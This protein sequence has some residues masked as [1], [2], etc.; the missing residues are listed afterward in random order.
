MIRCFGLT[1]CVS[2]MTLVSSGAESIR[3]TPQPQKFRTF[4][5]LS[6]RQVP[7]VLRRSGGTR[8][9]ATDGAEW[10]GIANGLVRLDPL[11][12]GGDRRQYF[13]G[14]RYLPDDRVRALLA[15]ES[16]GV[17]VRTETGVSH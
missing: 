11:A 7:P 16:G 15:D 3:L 9:I 6:D 2:V 13:A 10:K 12:A 4:Y 8:V 17:W 5:A 1:A 14:K